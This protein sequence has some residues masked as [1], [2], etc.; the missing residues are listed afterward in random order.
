MASNDRNRDRDRADDSGEPQEWVAGASRQRPWL[1]YAVIGALALILTLFFWPFGGD[2][3]ESVDPQPEQP[4]ETSDATPEPAPE[5][6]ADTASPIYLCTPGD[7]TQPFVDFLAH[8]NAG[9]FDR[10]R[11]MLPDRSHH[12]A[13]TN[14]VGTRAEQRQ[15][16]GFY[17]QSRTGLS[18]Q[19]AIIEYLERRH[20]AG[21][22]WRLLEFRIGRQYMD[23]RR[24]NPEIDTVTALVQRRAD[25]FSTH[26]VEGIATINCVEDLVIHWSFFTGDPELAEPIGVEHFLSTI[27]P[28]NPGQQRYM[29]VIVRVDLRPDGGALSEWIIERDEATSTEGLFVERVTVRTIDGEAIISYVYDGMRWHYDIRGWEV[30]ADA[31]DVPRLPFEIT[32]ARQ[33]PT[34]SAHV[35]RDM[36]DEIPD[37][38]T[39][40]ISRDIDDLPDWLHVY[41]RY[42]DAPIIEQAFDVVLDDGALSHSRFRVV[43]ESG[44]HFL[45][46]EIR[47]V[48]I[49]RAESY[50]GTLFLVPAGLGDLGF[51]Y[52]PPA[53]LPNG[54]L[55][56]TAERE[57]GGQRER[58]VLGTPAG[59]QIDLRVMPSRGGLDSRVPIDGWEPT[60]VTA[61][62]GP[63]EQP[64]LWARQSGGTFPVAAAWDTQRYRFE[65]RLVNGPPDSTEWDEDALL[66]LVE[67]LSRTP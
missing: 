24:H 12:R 2:Q 36:V 26:V 67:T 28:Y 3:P 29:R 64:V 45:T 35:I 37:E 7:V 9:N 22:R 54:L 46:P 27:G 19:D 50:D 38:G 25:D 51:Q 15:L 55:A 53:E 34:R 66:N 20:A 8:F 57:D 43:D 40:V 33:D 48:E 10:L 42:V 49:R 61:V 23:P 47:W 1:Q 14:T 13:P 63:E 60:W 30:R 32:V 56:L 44:M 52:Q 11:E 16:Y 65:L 17:H 31:I 21:E 59:F 6:T 5:P 58:Y 39:F 18:S 41:N 62:A 4:T